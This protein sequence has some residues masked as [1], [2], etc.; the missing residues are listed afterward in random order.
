MV[1][2][3]HDITP[4]VFGFRGSDYTSTFSVITKL[5]VS[6]SAKGCVS[7]RRARI[8]DKGGGYACFLRTKSV[9]TFHP[10][11]WSSCGATTNSMTLVRLNASN[12]LELKRYFFSALRRKCGPYCL[13]YC[14]NGNILNSDGCPTCRCREGSKSNFCVIFIDQKKF[15]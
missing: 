7:P 9:R 14:S 12:L 10:Y 1:L 15:T 11:P 5:E 8:E 13:I 4:Y 2:L 3:K 6:C